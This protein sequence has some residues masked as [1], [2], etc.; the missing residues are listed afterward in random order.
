VNNYVNGIFIVWVLVNGKMCS[1]AQDT[2]MSNSPKFT[3]NKSTVP[4][5]EKHNN[6]EHK[7]HEPT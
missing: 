4:N 5:K 3:Q 2:D 6:P 1:Q 7:K